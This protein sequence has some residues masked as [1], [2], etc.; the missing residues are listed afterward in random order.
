M[1]TVPIFQFQT[2]FFIYNKGTRWK[3]LN[4]SQCI[5]SSS[6][7]LLLK[8]IVVVSMFEVEMWEENQK[9]YITPI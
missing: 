4:K 6:N 8:N 1:I 2:E 3:D 7:L 5:T 9:N